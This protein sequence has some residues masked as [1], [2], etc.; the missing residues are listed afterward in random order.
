[1]EQRGRKKESQTV[2]SHG[3][4][5]KQKTALHEEALGSRGGEIEDFFFLAK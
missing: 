1:M 3:C 5:G 2:L 4:R